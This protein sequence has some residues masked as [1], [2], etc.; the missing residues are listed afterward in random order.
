MAATRVILVCAA[1]LA[2]GATSAL[3]AA[4]P[5]AETSRKI[6]PDGT[7]E[8]RYSNGSVKDIQPA[9]PTLQAAP[10]PTNASVDQALPAGPENLGLDP[11]AQAKYA[12]ALRAYYEYRISGYRHREDVFAWQFFSSKVIFWVVLAI[13]A[14]GIIF[15]AIQFF[16]GT[17]KE[18]EVTEMEA[19]LQGIKVSSPVLGVVVLTISIAFFYLYLVFVYPINNVF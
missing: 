5:L 11:T 3:C 14:A 12:A 9:V 8:I 18:P 1:F 4:A 2:A 13:V 16:A 6:L 17:R 7:V 10:G 15:S 19:S